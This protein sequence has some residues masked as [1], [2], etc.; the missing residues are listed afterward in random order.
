MLFG[1][2]KEWGTNTCYNMSETCQHYSMWK[3][4]DTK[5]HILY[6]SISMKPSE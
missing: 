1:H 3:K 6:D 2:E 5:D 4:P